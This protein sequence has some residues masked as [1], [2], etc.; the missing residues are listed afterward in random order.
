MRLPSLPLH[1]LPTVSK[2]MNKR[3]LSSMQRHNGLS[4]DG[5]P[6]VQKIFTKHL[7]KAAVQWKAISSWSKQ[8]QKKDGQFYKHQML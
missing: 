6:S 3:E 2:L 7:I 1:Q 8:S 5:I 4:M